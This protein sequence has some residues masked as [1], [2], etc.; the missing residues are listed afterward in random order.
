M[1]YTNKENYSGPRKRAK[2]VSD[3]LASFKKEFG[4]PGIATVDG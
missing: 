2:D 4:R 3:T 1:I